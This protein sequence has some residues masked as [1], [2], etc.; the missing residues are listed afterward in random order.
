MMTK[1][2]K[3]P[4]VPPEEMKTMRR[5]DEAAD[6]FAS[7]RSHKASEIAYDLCKVTAQSCLLINGGAATAVITYLAKD[8]IDRALFHI[9][10]P[11]LSHSRLDALH[12]RCEMTINPLFILFPRNT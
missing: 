1:P 3:K 4:T 10:F 7:D 12:T 5:L 6:K 11:A 2:P 9:C 8:N